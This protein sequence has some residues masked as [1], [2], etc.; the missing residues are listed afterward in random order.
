MGI[1]VYL[2]FWDVLGVWRTERSSGGNRLNRRAEGEKFRFTNACN[3]RLTSDCD[4]SLSLFKFILSIEINRV[5]LMSREIFMHRE[6]PENNF[7]PKD[8]YRPCG[9]AASY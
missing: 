8:S 4:V 2:G 1:C 7:K 6:M 9:L 5:I 3:I